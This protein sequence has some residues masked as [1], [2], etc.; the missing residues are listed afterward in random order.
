MNRWLLPAAI[1]TLLVVAWQQRGNG[2]AQ[3]CQGVAGRLIPGQEQ[4]RNIGRTWEESSPSS[5]ASNPVQVFC[6]SLRQTP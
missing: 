2:L 1:T 4:V 3:A 6:G 5:R